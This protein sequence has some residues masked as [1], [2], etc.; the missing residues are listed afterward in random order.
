MTQNFYNTPNEVLRDW[1]I[2]VLSLSKCLIETSTETFHYSVDPTESDW[3]SRISGPVVVN[4]LGNNTRFENVSTY[5]RSPTPI[6][7]IPHR[8]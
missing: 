1:L 5:P 7:L 2:T 4:F 8:V 6:R 3:K